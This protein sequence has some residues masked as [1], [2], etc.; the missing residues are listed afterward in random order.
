MADSVK[1]IRDGDIAQ[2]FINRPEA[3]NALNLET[4]QCLGGHL[5][6]LGGDDSVRGIVITGEGSAFSAGGDLKWALGSPQ[7]CSGAFREMAGVFHLGIVEIRRMSKPVIAAVNGVAA[8]GG[9]SLALACD[10]RVMARSAIL[11]QAYTARGLCVNGGGTFTLPRLVG[12]ARA[13]EIIA[14]DKPISSEQ[15]LAWNLVT[16]VVDNGQAL[17]EAMNMARELAD[18]SLNSFGWC[19]QLLM[20][21]FGAAL[22]AHLERERTGLVSCASHRDGREGLEAFVE[23]RK[24]VFKLD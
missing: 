18:G 1:L 21:S 24:P 7:G 14:F 16:K 20:D 5:I 4:M 9:F 11:Q 12:L 23:K 3:L 8:G 22:E 13:L 19:K 2:L 6:T 17:A 10:F 15:A